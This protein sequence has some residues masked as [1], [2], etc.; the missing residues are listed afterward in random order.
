[1]IDL[2]STVELMEKDKE[3]D[4][5]GALLSWDEYDALLKIAQAAQDV[6]L[7]QDKHT[8]NR[9]AN[10]LGALDGEDA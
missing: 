7:C 8:I 5:M 9:L 6:V 3:V 2:K 10:L 1:M 4:A